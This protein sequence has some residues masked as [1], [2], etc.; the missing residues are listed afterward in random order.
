VT[1]PACREALA[2]DSGDLGSSEG[3]EERPVDGPLG[4]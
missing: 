1:C 4:L 3:D 2:G